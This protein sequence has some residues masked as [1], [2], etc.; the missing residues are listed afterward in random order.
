[1]RSV[2]RS[3]C[4]SRDPRHRNQQRTPRTGRIVHVLVALKD[5]TTEYPIDVCFAKSASG[6]RSAGTA[7]SDAGRRATPR[8]ATST[9]DLLCKSHDT[10]GNFLRLV[11]P[12]D[13]CRDRLVS[14][15]RTHPSEP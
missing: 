8:P 15:R 1:M 9:C 6:L 2:L 14:I 5:G 11:R 4:L 10:Y 3:R 7:P 12:I 13:P